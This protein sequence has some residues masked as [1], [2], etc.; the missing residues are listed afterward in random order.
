MTISRTDANTLN[1]NSKWQINNVNQDGYV[2][3]GQANANK[4]WATDANGN[5]GWTFQPSQD[6]TLTSTGTS[7]ASTG[8]VLS[9]NGGTVIIKGDG[10]T[11]NASSNNT[12]NTIT[13]A[14]I[15]RVN[16]TYT[17][18]TTNGSNPDLVLTASSGAT[19]IVNMNGTANEVTV[20]G[21]GTNTLTFGLPDDVTIAGELTVSGTGQSS[22]GGQVTIPQTPSADTD[23]ASKKYVDDLVS[24]G[25][26]FRGTFNA[27]T[28]EILSGVSTG[29]K[30][31]NCPGGAGTRIAVAVGDYYI[32]ATAGGSFYCSGATL[33]IGDSIIAT[34]AANADASVVTG[35]SVV[36]SDEGVASFT[37][38]NGTFVSAGTVN[39][40]AT[41]AVTMGTIDLSATGTKNN[42]TFL[43]GDNTWA[44][45][46]YVS[47]SAMTTSTLGLGKIKYDFGSTPA[48]ES[49]STTASRTYG[50]TKNA[51][52]QLVVNVPWVNSSDVNSVTASGAATALSGL[53]STP[54][55]GS[56]VIGLDIHGR[57]SLGTP[58]SD[59]ELMIYDTSTSKN[60]KVLVSDLAS[61][62]GSAATNQVTYWTSANEI[63]GAAG[64]T[65]AG[66]ANG[67]V[68]MGGA[69]TVAGDVGIG[70]TGLYTTTRA[71]NLPGKGIS[72]KNDVNGSNNN[73][74][75]IYN[76][77][78]GSSSNLVFATGSA[79]TA[80]TLEH[81]GDA[82]FAG[83]IF[84]PDNR[85]IGWNGGYSAS[86]P[87]LAAV[88]TTM[89]MFPSGATSGAQFTLTPTTATFA[90]DVKIADNKKLILGIPGDDLQI[91]HDGG[92]SKITDAGTGD[93]FIGADFLG[94]E[95]SNHGETMAKFLADGPVKLYYDNVQ[96]FQTTSTGIEVSGGATF[97]AEVIFDNVISGV[98]ASFVSTASGSTV[99]SAT[100]KAA[101]A[102]YFA[103]NTGINTN[104]IV[105]IRDDYAT[106]SVNSAGGIKISSSPGNDVFLVKRNE[107]TSSF[108]GLQN[109]SGTEFITVNMSTGNMSFNS[110]TSINRGNQ[111]S[112]ELLLGGTTDGGFVDFDGTNLQFNTQ[113]DPNT[114]TF[115]N[116]NKSHGGIQILGPDGGSLIKFATSEGN[117]PSHVATTKV[118]INSSGSVSFTESLYIPDAKK[119]VLGSGS[120]FQIYHD[121]SNSY[122]QNLIGWLN[123]PL[124]QNGVTFANA[125][126]SNILAKFTLDNRVIFGDG[127][128]NG[129]F[130]ASNTVLAIKGT[131]SGGEGILQITG[132]GNSA[133]DNVG[134]IDFHSYAETDPMCSIRSVR[135][136]ADDVGDL[137]FYTN[138]G[139]GAASKRMVITDLGDVGINEPTPTAKLQVNG[140]IKIGSG[141]GSGSDS[142]GYNVQVNSF[143]FGAT[144]ETGLLVRNDAQTNEYAT[145]GF[146]YSENNRTPV[147]IGSYITD[148]GAATKG[149]F[150][151]G[152][153]SS[154]TNT[155]YPTERLWV[156]PNGQVIFNPTNSSEG[157]IVNGY[158]AAISVGQSATT[159]GAVATYG[160]LA[161][162]WMNYA[163][164][165]G[166]D[167]VSYSL[168][169]VTVLSSQMISGGTSS[170]T[171]TSVSGV[172]KLTM[173][174]SDTYSVYATEIRTANT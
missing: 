66:G 50:V 34:A 53:S 36:Q 111:T 126:F 118:T 154:T 105:H 71:L 146:G 14:A 24:G 110:D 74:S 151:I 106:T 137:E 152:T 73:W 42:T 93:L 170:R 161:M 68:T 56:V 165:I 107:T 60:V 79:L 119:V 95:S 140:K 57:A 41:G 64:F 96:K 168:S 124:S 59:D 19:D 39:S 5:P 84:L 145:I 6:Q 33:D 129:A 29:S 122:I 37:N 15:N 8:V 40:N 171:Y 90:G 85:D 157:G 131:T 139:G 83:S 11:I 153:R 2:P 16:T 27:A 113:R 32:V 98:R 26:T 48:A 135:G 54:N 158:R 51:S 156:E 117:G 52:D 70:A 150:V 174:G 132:K 87:T 167:L 114:G 149:R 44:V 18:P 62:A 17:L 25:L 28:G 127:S 123:I 69:L 169:Q 155:V 91:Y 92:N 43:R 172:L 143:T 115:I 128:I 22:F 75:Y 23:A 76:T 77:A 133:T 45:P 80:L 63:G 104:Q 10:T 166:Y 20:E 13:L 144:G 21:S 88:G 7:N 103:S 163:G 31:Y 130:G 109:S 30:L 89:K 47:Y 4:F 9:Q 134:K 136:N 97:S 46:A 67:A 125:D 38:A 58:A 78:T 120:D 1:F 61:Y 116:A 138:S 82:I 173:G 102:G 141:G 3:K 94:I 162:V 121:G 99:L 65:F 100:G 112:G 55:T 148:G 35:W 12:T 101:V 147:V 142:G 164:N 81:D 49:Q 72:F 159:I 86:K 160:G 108:F